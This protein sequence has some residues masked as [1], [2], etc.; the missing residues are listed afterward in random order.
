MRQIAA[1]FAAVVAAA[2]PGVAYAAPG[3]SPVRLIIDTD[4][5]SDVDDAGALAIANAAQDNGKAKL[6]AVMVDTPSKWG[7]PAVDAIN[8]FYGHGNVPI[9]TLKPNDESTWSKNYIQYLAENFPNSIKS[10]ERA[11]DAVDLYRKVLAAQPD[12]SVTIAAVGYENNLADLLDS[13]ADQYSSLTGMELVTKKVKLL[14]VMGGPWN[15]GNVSA[16]PPSRESVR[17]AAVRAVNDWPTR[18]VINNSPGSDV[19]TGSDLFVRTPPENPVR[20]AYEIYVGYG[21][22]RNSWD[23]A[24]IFYDTYGKAGLLDLIGGVGS[25]HVNPDG[26][27]AWVES[28]DKDQNEVVRTASAETFGRAMS[29]LMVQPPKR[30]KSSWLYLDDARTSPVATVP[31]GE[32]V[33]SAEATNPGP[34]GAHEIT[35]DAE[36]PAGWTASRTALGSDALAPRRSSAWAWRVAVPGDAAPGSYDV[37]LTVR[38]RSGGRVQSQTQDATVQVPYPSLAAAFDNVGITD[39]ADH[40]PGNFDGFGNS[41]S[42]QALADVGLAPGA[43]VAHDGVQFVWPD[44]AA[45]RADNVELNGQTIALSGSGT[46]LGLLGAA[47]SGAHTGTGSVV[48]ADGTEQ[49]FSLTLSDWFSTA[50]AGGNE[51]AATTAHLNRTTPKPLNPV[52]VWYAAI[53]LEPGK[54]LAAI[55]LPD[56]APHRMHVF[57]MGVGSLHEIY[58]PP[59]GYYGYAPSVIRQGD[60]EYVWTCHNDAHRVIRDHIY[61]TKLV[62]GRV[63]EDRSVLHGTGTGWDSFH[64]CDPSVVAGNFHYGGVRYRYAMLYL[65]N[66]VDASRHNQVGVAFARSLE[67]PWV[68][69]P[70]PLVPFANTSQWGAGQPS[71]VSLD[72]GSGRVLLFYTQGDTATRAFRRV[73]DLGDMDHPVIGPAVPV[74]TSG[75]TSRTGGSD[76]LNNY[77]VAYDAERR[78][79]LAVREQHPYPTDNPSWIGASV[80]VASIDARDIW[81]GGGAWTVE[82]TIDPALTGLPRNHNAG[83]VRTDRGLLPAGDAPSVVFTDSCSGPT[84]DSLFDYDLWQ[85]DAPFSRGGE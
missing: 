41:F 34:V 6:L 42:S 16:P 7:A 31:G 81:R 67:G 77:D 28:P 4:I 30:S 26:T 66:D 59:A 40:G 62:D 85:I 9:G 58:N 25:D 11:P 33:L 2:V 70:D 45:G 75:L 18:L 65:G 15:F 51:L 84:C 74:S 76:W 50:P 79:F 49:P 63:V 1:I 47:A 8:T 3:N 72:R 43:T 71:A 37:K 57:A 60:S 48:Y 32:T 35:V 29:G 38:Y 27:S 83:L 46:K 19:F 52:R 55:T 22:S 68:K 21:N 13:G 20:K 14:S 36:P 53:P 44:A 69:Y 82:G 5:Y 39:D 78:R 23:P 80:Q 64:N 61:F 17:A 56:A 54:P 10:G 24:N 73:L 12:H